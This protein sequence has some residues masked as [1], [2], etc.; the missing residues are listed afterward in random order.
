[1]T[2]S[3]AAFEQYLIRHQLVGAAADYI[4]DAKAGL[5]RDIGTGSYSCVVT[6]YQSRKMG[7]TVNTESRTAECLYA[8]HLDFDPDIEAFFEQPPT[9][10]C[11]RTDR[12]GNRRLGGYT[13]DVVVLGR[14]GPYV[15]QIKTEQELLRKAAISPDWYRDADGLFHDRAAERAFDAIGLSHIVVSTAQLNKLRAS[16][17]SLLLQSLE[18][19]PSNEALAANVR[20]FFE[21]Y[22]VTRLSDLASAVG[23][24][25]LAPLLRLI[26][27]HVMFTDIERFSLTEPDSCFVS[28][29]E[30]LLRNEVYEAFANFRRSPIAS[31]NED[32]SQ[33]VLPLAKHLGRGVAIVDQLNAGLKG[34]SAR[35]WRAQI[36]AGARNG[37]SPVA[38]VTPGFHRSGNREAKRPIVVLAFAE[39]MVRT[40]WVSDARPTPASLWRLYKSTAEAWHPGY[41]PVSRQTFRKI[42]D[43]TADQLAQ[44]RGGNRSSN[45]AAPPTDVTAR[46]LKPCRP[47]EVASCDHYLC[48]LHCVVLHANGLEY[49]MQPWLTVMRDCYTG[50]VLAFWL[51]LRAP[52]RRSCA[53]IIRQCLRAHGRLPEWLIVDRGADFRSEYFSALMSHCRINLMLRPPGHPR[54]G[55][56]AERFFGQFKD[57]WLSCRAGNRVSVREVRSVSGSHQPQKLASLS[58]LDLW[59]DLVE[60]SR[61]FDQ[62]TAPSRTS[63]PAMLASEG[64]RRYSCSGRILPYDET[65]VIASAVDDGNYRV[66]P[67][68]GLHI[69][70]FHYWN[71]RLAQCTR[72]SAPV[73]R[74]PQDPYRIYALVDGQWTTCLASPAPAYDLKHPLRQAA[75]GVVVLDGMTL[76]KAVREDADRALMTALEKR[77]AA[78]PLFV[79]AGDTTPNTPG[80]EAQPTAEG[81]YFA[82]VAQRDLVSVESASW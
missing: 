54:Y 20:Q 78:P 6:E 17:I 26:A 70:D 9:V 53:L 71:P 76:R 45:A 47:F 39:H 64:L 73:R 46:S 66:D 80:L 51:S 16:N 33:N 21:Q 55:S 63:S 35:R 28:T 59:E 81:D 49:A 43:A 14:A 3:E 65:F 19:S 11:L 29:T 27:Q 32:L 7:V 75:E 22:P 1:M 41:R 50:S 44:R 77:K 37:Q 61:W 67:Q 52:S 10:D 25:D 68:R 48:D 8:I 24:I 74:D 56:E 58:L 42:F 34:R 62:Y 2:Y 57:L 38:A 30:G 4:R 72:R 82:E 31:G 36:A 60:F 13:P 12:R 5:A 69:G 79:E 15:V 18:Y 40:K 23:T